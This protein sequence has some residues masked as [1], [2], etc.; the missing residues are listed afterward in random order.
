MK[1]AWSAC[2]CWVSRVTVTGESPA[3][4]RRNCSRAGTKSPKDR[5]CRSRSGST[6]LILGLL[7]RQD[8]GGQ[9]LA[10]ARLLVDALVVH[11]WRLPL[12]HADPSGDLPRLVVAVADHQTMA[13]L[14]ALISQLG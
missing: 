5:P 12:D 1:A 3:A 2:H 13:A 7:R 8:R 11:S 6:S 14:I 10:L 4:L 9:P